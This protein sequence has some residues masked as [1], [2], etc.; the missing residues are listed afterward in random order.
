MTMRNPPIGHLSS[1]KFGFDPG[2]AKI[3]G[4]HLRPRKVLRSNAH[5]S[6]RS[7]VFYTFDYGRTKRRCMTKS[8]ILVIFVLNDPIGTEVKE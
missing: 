4:L 1:V 3:S 2:L 6:Y 5:R 7:V 8:N